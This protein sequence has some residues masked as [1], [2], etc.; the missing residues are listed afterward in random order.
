MAG[1]NCGSRPTI[2]LEPNP[3]VKSCWS[4]DYLFETHTFSAFWLRSSVVSVLISLISDTVTIGYLDVKLI[5][6]KGGVTRRACM[7]APSRVASVL[8]CIRER[9]TPFGGNSIKTY[10]IKSL[11]K[12]LTLVAEEVMF[13]F[14]SCGCV[15]ERAIAPRCIA[16]RSPSRRGASQVAVALGTGTDGR[17]AHACSR[18]RG[19]AHAMALCEE[20]VCM[21]DIV[22]TSKLL[23][24]SISRSARF[25][26]LGYGGDAPKTVTVLLSTAPRP[27]HLHTRSSC[28]RVLARNMI[29]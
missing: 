19:A 16:R 21:N 14:A 18:R 27:P 22:C 20:D 7:S 24:L 26:A 15:D 1:L 23:T 2:Q 3:K 29:K 28:R 6:G 13:F 5:F 8:H 4:Q 17:R 11:A 9:L 10:Y 25:W 12:Q